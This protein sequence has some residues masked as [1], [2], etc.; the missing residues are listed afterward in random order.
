MK[1]EW[2][3]QEKEFYIASK[4][5][6]LLEIPTYQYLLIA[7]QGDPNGEGFGQAVQA[8]YS[9]SYGIKMGLKKRTLPEANDYTVF[10]LEGIWTT[11][12]ARAVTEVLDKNDLQYQ[13]M[14]RQPDF[15]TAAYV[16]EIRQ[17]KSDTPLID[18]VQFT[19]LTDGL[20][21][22]ML[23][24]GPYDEEA[25]TFQKMEANLAKQGLKKRL[26]AGYHHREI[27]LSDPRRTAPE[28]MKTTL[29]LFVES[30]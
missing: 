19:T 20:A 7:G 4:K 25:A 10:P 28:K 13:I 22:Q 23:H 3:K 27:Y 21:Y 1:V 14:I 8:L 18:Q 15:V 6:V 16:A 2:R 17:E 12:N 24:I 9:F 11:T 29:R 26:L 30:Q 5:G